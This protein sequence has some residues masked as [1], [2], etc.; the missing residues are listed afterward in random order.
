V[1]AQRIQVSKLPVKGDPV[2]FTQWRGLSIA[3]D[4]YRNEGL[5]GYYKGTGA[6][7]LMYATRFC[8]CVFVTPCSCTCRALPCN[9]ARMKCANA[10]STA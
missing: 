8:Q 4:I 2:N 6:F 5:R 1:I 7:L 9:G 3:R 10:F